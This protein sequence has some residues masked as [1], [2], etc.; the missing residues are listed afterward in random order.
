VAT[1]EDGGE[2]GAET[3]GGAAALAW[4]SADS[5]AAAEL[6]KGVEEGDCTGMAAERSE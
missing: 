5:G 4:D 1:T 6:E 2:G 3:G